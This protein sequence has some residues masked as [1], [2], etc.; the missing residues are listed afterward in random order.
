MKHPYWFT[1]PPTAKIPDVQVVIKICIVYKGK[2]QGLAH[3]K[4]TDPNQMMFSFE[5]VGVFT[6]GQLHMGPFTFINGNRWGG[7]FSQMIGG[8]P[9]DNHFFTH[10]YPDGG[11]ANIEADQ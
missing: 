7:C 3:I 5:G 1:N 2:P 9:A 11:R 8:R 10:F 6:D 4:Y